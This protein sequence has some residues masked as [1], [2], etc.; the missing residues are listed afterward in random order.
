MGENTGK[1][2]S[3]ISMSSATFMNN[4]DAFVLH[5]GSH[6]LNID[7]DNSTFSN[8]PNG[9]SQLGMDI[10][11]SAALTHVTMSNLLFYNNQN[12]AVSI[13]TSNENECITAY[14]RLTNVT[15]YGTTIRDLFTAFES[16]SVYIFTVNTLGSIVFNKVNFTSNHFLRHKGGVLVVKSQFTACNP[17]NNL[18]VRSV[19][20]KLTDCTIFNNT[21]FDDVAALSVLTS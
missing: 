4:D 9:M 13:Q 15:V 1:Y 18:V 12:G 6:D 2:S 10:H 16:A 20:I 19:S 21:A 7:I 3:Y 8:T 11:F 14:I 17:D 5:A